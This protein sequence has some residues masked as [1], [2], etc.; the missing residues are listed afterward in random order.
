M[1]QNQNFLNESFK[2]IFEGITAHMPKITFLGIVLAYI[3]TAALNV[4]F[5]PLPLAI[6]IASAG[7]IQFMRFAI[8]FM[9]FLNPTGR[10]SPW[11]AMI[12]TGATIISLVEMG[13]SI[14]NLHKSGAEF[15]ALFLF[16][17][18]VICSGY[19]LELNFISKG[20]EA[21]GMSNKQ[22]RGATGRDETPKPQAQQMT[23]PARTG[24]LYPQPH[25]NGNEI[26]NSVTEGVPVM[27]TEVERNP[28]GYF[29]SP[30]TSSTAVAN[31]VSGF[32]RRT[33]KG[34]LSIAEQLEKAKSNL[35][36]QR[37]K[38]NRKVGNPETVQQNIDRLT[39][40]IGQLKAKLDV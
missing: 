37:S 2:E 30:K 12:A 38:L 27:M 40:E 28:I 1:N 5:I 36:A 39:K 7:V 33:K 4:F 32:Q 8:V 19:A 13:F 25:Q 20:A 29:P 16:G 21:F 3:V 24:L 10:R 35:R 31:R 22:H 17:A 11:P 14:S 6:A 23:A 9:D 15:Y 26:R 18:M 34:S